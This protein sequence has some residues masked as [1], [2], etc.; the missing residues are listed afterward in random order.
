MRAAGVVLPSIAVQDPA[1]P[2][3]R[4]GEA[5]VPAGRM[6][7]PAVGRPGG[8][9]RRLSALLRLRVSENTGGA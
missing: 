4:T 7:T 6:E 1:L 8:G 2:L 5:G 9:R 3:R